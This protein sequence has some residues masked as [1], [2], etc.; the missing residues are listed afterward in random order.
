MTAQILSWFL[1]LLFP[2]VCQ[3]CGLEGGYLCLSC[4]GRIET[5]AQRCP[6]CRKD[7]VLGRIHPDC[8]ADPPLSGILVASDYKTPAIQSLIWHLKYSG[9]SPMADNLALVAMDFL[10]ANDLLD[11]F[12]ES[13]IVAVPL[14]AKRQRTRGF[15][16]ADL[17][18][19]ALARKLNL[20]ISPA[21]VR[22]KN[23]KTQ[24]G[25][26][27]HKRLENLK[28]AFVINPEAFDLS[29]KKILLI[30]DVATTGAT[31]LE[32]ARTLKTQ[33]PAEIWGLVIARN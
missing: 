23:T 6:L 21:L 18:A 28:D 2:L 31:L 17:I 25:K 8:A 29:G 32:C 13:V 22:S 12:S 15:N 19:S 30:D 16:Q 4:Q 14:H 20:K 26:K 5:P 33:N 3:G 10:V 24:V 11:Y 9:I 1:D 27:K 7:S